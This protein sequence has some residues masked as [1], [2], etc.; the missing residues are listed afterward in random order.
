M[1]R[2]EV[3]NFRHSN[4][5]YAVPLLQC[6]EVSRGVRI[7]QVPRA[8]GYV[9]GIANIRGDVVT[10]IDVTALL[11]GNDER[12]YESEADG[13]IVLRSAEATVA[14]LAD[15]ALDVMSVD[16]AELDTAPSQFE[17]TGAAYLAAAF[18][19]KGDVALVLRP[20]ALLD[21]RNAVNERESRRALQGGVA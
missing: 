20:E 10:V 15:E 7:N 8:P 9:A 14:L 21:A 16:E 11:T 12:R 2:L 3:L 1:K 6:R 19:W 5:I 4:R 13:L 17:E 18:R